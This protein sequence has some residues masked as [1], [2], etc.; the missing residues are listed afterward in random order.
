MH[1]ETTA[2]QKLLKTLIYSL[3]L[4]GDDCDQIPSP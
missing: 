3:K 4:S 1:S 2:D